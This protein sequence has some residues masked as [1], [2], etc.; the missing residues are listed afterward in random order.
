MELSVKE[1]W[2]PAMRTR[3]RKCNMFISG[4][5]SAHA[6]FQNRESVTTGTVVPTPLLTRKSRHWSAG[7]VQISGFVEFRFYKRQIS[8]KDVLSCFVVTRC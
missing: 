5:T 4:F 3:S 8:R 2:T 7:C 1:A 6:C